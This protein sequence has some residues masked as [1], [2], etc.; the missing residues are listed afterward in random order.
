MQP[1]SSLVTA[2]PTRIIGPIKINN[3]GNPE[4]IHVPMAT[5]ETP[6]WP[7]TGRGGRVTMETDGISC[8]VSR[9]YMARSILLEASS[10]E[11]VEWVSNHLNKIPRLTWQRLIAQTS[12]FAKFHSVHVEIAGRSIYARFSMTTGDA[13]GHNMVTKACDLIAQWLCKE[14]NVKYISVSANYCCDKKSSAINGI[15]GRGKHVSAE[16]LIPRTVCEQLLKTTPERLI[17]LNFRKNWVGTMLAGGVRSAN[18]HF[19][20]ILLA[21]YLATGQDGANIIEASQGSVITNLLGQDLYMNINLPNLIV[22]TIGNGKNDPTIH[23]YFNMMLC[24]RHQ[25]HPGDQARQLAK[26]IAAAVLCGELSLLA[27]LTNP[28]ELVDTHMRLERTTHA[29][30]K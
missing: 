24:H 3:N 27:A 12:R 4:F 22:G 1:K 15:L 7:S 9:D 8:I 30:P 25:D 16:I 20:N 5:Y 18:A 13:A 6:L 21:I 23:S 29:I 10:L 17:E 14:F 2:I 11:H 28:G 19:A 26:G